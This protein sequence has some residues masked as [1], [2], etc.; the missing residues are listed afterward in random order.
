MNRQ[1]YGLAALL[2]FLAGTSL[3]AYGIDT[4]GI[5]SKNKIVVTTLA[6]TGPNYEVVFGQLKLKG[7]LPDTSLD[8]D[9]SGVM[10][11]D[12]GSNTMEDYLHQHYRAFGDYFV[13]TEKT[14]GIKQSDNPDF[15]PLIE[16]IDWRHIDKLLF[17]LTVLFDLL[18]FI[19]A[20]VCYKKYV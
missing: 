4:L 14:V 5:L 11:A 7:Q 3:L 16:I 8:F 20:R 9:V 13:I 2:F 10:I 17:W 19:L 12:N 1:K 15:H 6:T 18:L